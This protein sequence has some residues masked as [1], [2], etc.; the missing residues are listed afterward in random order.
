MPKIPRF[1]RR[2]PPTTAR[3]KRLTAINPERLDPPTLLMRK[4]IATLGRRRHLSPP[5]FRSEKSLI[6]TVM[7]AY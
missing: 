5:F 2:D 6:A 7:C 1:T 3:A 4:T